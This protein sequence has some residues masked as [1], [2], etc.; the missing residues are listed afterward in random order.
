ML[1]SQTCVLLRISED[2][3]K[4]YKATSFRLKHY[5]S[6]VNWGLVLRDGEAG[7]LK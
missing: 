4:T 3:L 1:T 5:T 2:Q 6:T 7:G